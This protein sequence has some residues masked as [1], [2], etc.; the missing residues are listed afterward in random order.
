MTMPARRPVP[1][2]TK[3][4]LLSVSETILQSCH[5]TSQPLSSW[6]EELRQ[7]LATALEHGVHHKLD[8]MMLQTLCEDWE[9]AITGAEKSKIRQVV[10]QLLGPHSKW[11]D[12]T[13][14][15]YTSDAADE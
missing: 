8:M 6:S 13:C 1:S 10:P 5:N 3:L 2:L 12:F 15:L 7:C 4:S 9:A 11:L 14:L